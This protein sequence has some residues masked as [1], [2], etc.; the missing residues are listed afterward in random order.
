MGAAPGRCII[1]LTGNQVLQ[2]L[3]STHTALPR[4]SWAGPGLSRIVFGIGLRL[5]AIDWRLVW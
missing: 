4:F 2:A 5:V 3:H 1:A